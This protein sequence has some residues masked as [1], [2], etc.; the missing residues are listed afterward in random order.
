MLATNVKKQIQLSSVPKNN[1]HIL[2]ISFSE[3]ELGTAYRITAVLLVHGFD[4]LEATAETMD[5]GH[6][7]DVFL[8]RNLQN[9]QLNDS[10][11]ASIKHD[12]DTLFFG[13]MSVMEYIKSH[14]I[15]VKKSLTDKKT[16]TQVRLYNPEGSD[17]TVMDIIAKDRKGLLFQVTQILFLFGI[18]IISFKAETSEGT[19]RDSFL[20]Q[21]EKGG[22]LDTESTIPRLEAALKPLL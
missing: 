18:D 21:R 1:N 6:V 16:E 5:D 19:V 3:D 4:I 12:L 8:I 15:D 7:R 13:D 17:N 20:L 2:K 11:L 22:R 14:S 10:M 9:K